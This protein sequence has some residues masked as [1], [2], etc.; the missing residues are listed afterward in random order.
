MDSVVATCADAGL[1]K[2]S[3]DKKPIDFSTV[4]IS[5]GLGGVVYLG[6]SLALHGVIS[7]MIG[8]MLGVSLFMHATTFSKK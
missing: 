8:L 6:C 5:T 2:Q 7:A 4:V 1:A 3:P